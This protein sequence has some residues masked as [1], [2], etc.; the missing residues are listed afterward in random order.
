MER[1]HLRRETLLALLRSAHR[2]VGHRREATVAAAVGRD[3]GGERG[4]QRREPRG[5]RELLVQRFDRGGLLRELLVTVGDGLRHGGAAAVGSGRVRGEF[6]D[7]VGRAAAHLLRE[8]ELHRHLRRALCVRSD[9][10]ARLGERRVRL[11]VRGLARAEPLD[12]RLTVLVQL[13]HLGGR[14]HALLPLV[15]ELRLDL[16]PLR[17]LPS[18]L[19][20]D[21]LELGTQLGD[22]PLGHRDFTRERVTR[23][24]AEVV[25]RWYGS[26]VGSGVAL[27][28][29]LQLTQPLA[30][31]LDTGGRRRGEDDGGWLRPTTHAAGWCI[32]SGRGGTT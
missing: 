23:L 20:V 29:R 8:A 5:A 21:Q 2:P 6:Y 26:A 15:L 3:V 17:G 11:L 30:K 9:D 7:G 12:R 28:V 22:A 14:V 4:G 1:L 25:V 32:S 10:A 13:R 31:R 19:L 16:L 24:V 18:Q 27:H